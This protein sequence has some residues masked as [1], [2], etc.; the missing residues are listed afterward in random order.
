MPRKKNSKK[1]AE[2]PAVEQAYDMNGELRTLTSNRD[3]RVKLDDDVATFLS[4]GGKIVEIDRD[5]MADPP[6]KPV[7]NY[8]SRPI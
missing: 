6:R 8:G 1:E 3:S 7:S 5:V 2:T 4:K